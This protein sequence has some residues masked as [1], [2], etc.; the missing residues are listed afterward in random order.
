MKMSETSLELIFRAAVHSVITGAE[1][2]LAT[3]YLMN[4]S[5]N[6]NRWGVTDKALEEALPALIGKPVGCCEGYEIKR[7]CKNPMNIG[8]WVATDKPDGYALGTI[9]ITDPHV[10]EKLTAGEW[11]P[12]SVV[13]TSYRESCSRC[14]ENITEDPF[15]HD[16]V[17]EGTAYVVVESFNFSR[18][19]FIEDPAY[20]QAGLLKLGAE[21]RLELCAG[22]YTSQSIGGQRMNKDRDA[23]AKAPEDT[24]WNLNRADYTLEQLK[25]AAAVVTGDGDTKADCRLIHHLPNGTLVWRGVSAAGASIRGARDGVQLSPA[26]MAKA[27]RHLEPH[28]HAFDREAPWESKGQAAGSPGVNLNP[29]EKR[30]MQE[31]IEEL[32]ATVETLKT[33]VETLKAAAEDPGEGPDDSEE[34]DPKITALEAKV[35]AMEDEKHNGLV[36][37]CLKARF[38][39]GLVTDRKKDREALKEIPDSILILMAEDADRIAEKLEKTRPAGPKLKYSKDDRT[40]LDAAVDEMREKLGFEPRV[41]EAET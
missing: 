20:P 27:K 38:K 2:H 1:E 26:D 14:G 15:A 34:T 39:A 37:A 5:E 7:H 8:K 19:D 11:G 16:H 31:K 24:P 41:K 28:Y 29:E 33:E 35:K 12:V 23:F 9:E 22:Y 21:A 30:K 36:E 4:T 6:R 13:I 3:F 17:K 40:E 25:R 10:W 32:E 18:V